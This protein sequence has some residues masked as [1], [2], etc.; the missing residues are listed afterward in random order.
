VRRSTRLTDSPSCLVRSEGDVSPFVEDLLRRQ[1]QDVPTPKLTLEI[2]PE[3]VLLQ[4]M[5]QDGGRFEIWAQ[6]LFDQASLAE[7]MMLEDPSAFV[8]RMNDLLG[9][10]ADQQTTEA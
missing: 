9:E 5:Q 4:R 6:W 10:S 3:H 7:G 8:Q 2:T 1:G